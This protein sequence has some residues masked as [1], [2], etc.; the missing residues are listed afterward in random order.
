MFLTES[1]VF[2]LKFVNFFQTNRFFYC[3]CCILYTHAYPVVG[4]GNLMSR[5]IMPYTLT[6]FWEIAYAVVEITSL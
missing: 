1:C 2:N 3:F 5:H 6:I 4:T